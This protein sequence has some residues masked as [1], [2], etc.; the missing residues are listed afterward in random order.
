MLNLVVRKE[1][2]RILKVKI[3]REVSLK[4]FGTKFMKIRSAV[5]L[6]TDGET[7]KMNTF[8]CIPKCFGQAQN[9]VSEIEG[10]RAQWTIRVKDSDWNV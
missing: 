5:F 2:A 4:I 7:N 6:L 8:L 3:V 10:G 9:L 1:T